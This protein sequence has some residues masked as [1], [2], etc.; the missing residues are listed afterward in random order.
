MSDLKTELY[1]VEEKIKE[2]GAELQ[3]NETKNSKVK[4]TFDKVKT[5]IRLSKE[6]VSSIT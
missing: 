4:D 2:I 6:K 1:S 3:K 5:D